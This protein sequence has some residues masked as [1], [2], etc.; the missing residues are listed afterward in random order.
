[1]KN[2][3]LVLLLLCLPLFSFAQNTDTRVYEM[4]IYWPHEGKMADMQARFR[5]HTTKLFE[6]HG[7]TNIGY[8]VPQ[9]KPDSV[10]IY[11]LAYPSKA[12]RDTSWKYFAADPEWKKVASESE[13]NGKL[14]KKV[15]QKFMTTTDFSPL[16]LTNEGN[17][18]FEL[19]TYTASKYNLGLLMARFR[20]H[21]VKLFEKHGMRNLIY[22]NQIGKD[23]QLVYL[24]SHKT[25]AAA[26]VSFDA[27]RLDPDWIS[28]RE[29]SEKLAKGSITTAV[30][31]QFLIP[32][33]F[34]PL[35]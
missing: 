10:L 23:D 3:F 11:V 19:R 30:L 28:A 22:W 12:A 7:M 27:F 16:D 34:S 35:K 21:T 4:R 18:V 13:K 20:N 33:D 24:L 26:K 32:T 17:R 8:F 6:K 25:T 31:S 1:M 2:R 9:N 5:N 29:A 15:E 14:V